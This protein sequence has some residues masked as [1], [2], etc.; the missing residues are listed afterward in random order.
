MICPNSNCKRIVS[1]NDEICE[2]CGTNLKAH[3]IKDYIKDTNRL[4]S[5][6]LVTVELLKNY[7]NKISKIAVSGTREIPRTEGKEGGRE[8]LISGNSLDQLIDK[9][10]KKSMV[11]EVFGMVANNPHVTENP[12]FNQKAM[13]T[14]PIYDPE[15]MAVNAFAAFEPEKKVYLIVFFDGYLNFMLA[16]EAIFKMKMYDRL[17]RLGEQLKKSQYHFPPYEL[18]SVLEELPKEAKSFDKPFVSCFETI[19]HELGHICY[20][21]VF[22]PGY[23]G[24]TLDESRNMERDA[25]SFASSIINRSLFN[26]DIFDSFIKCCIA[27]AVVEKVGGRVEPHTHPLAYERLLNS[28]RN[29][30]ALAKKMGIDEDLVKRLF[31]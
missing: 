12:A 9:N 16:V 20:D 24:M 22:G 27:W 31:G 13:L 30:S 17:T 21:H 7:S 29:N 3:P 6:G 4:V 8:E 23:S 14:Y 28:I 19:A 15:E 2:H 11:Q 10:R 25:D 5:N 1:P 18:A 26:K